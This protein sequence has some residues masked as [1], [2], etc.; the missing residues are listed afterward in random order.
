MSFKNEKRRGITPLM[1]ACDRDP[2]IA[3]YLFRKKG[4]D[5]SVQDDQGR[6]VLSIAVKK[7][8]Q[9]MIEEFRALRP[10][11]FFDEFFAQ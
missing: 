8:S 2:N 10:D 9:A 7:K 6:T 11:L 5:P 4:A 3:L 1:L